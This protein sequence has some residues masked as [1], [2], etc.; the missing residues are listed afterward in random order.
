MP[1][2][3][4][5]PAAPRDLR[6]APGSVHVWRVALDGPLN[7][8]AAN[9]LSSAER[10]RAARFHFVRDR[11]RYIA[12]HGALR[13]ILARYLNADPAAL[14]FA[15]GSYGKPYLVD[16]ALSFSLSHS[17][18]MALVGVAL[19]HEVGVDVERVRA[20]ADLAAV[21]ARFFSLVE[22][23]VWRAL[24]A[25]AQTV[26][27]FACWTRKEAYMKARGEGFALPA[28]SFDVSLA[29][30][31]PARLL[32]VQ[33]DAAEAA[34]WSLVALDAG[35]GYEAALAFAG[36]MPVIACHDGA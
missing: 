20:V 19:E 15:A 7:A 23:S 33:G 35:A 29:P 21:A 18:E 22:L 36:P 8:A 5:W 11:E 34:R 14:V 16:Q 12:A 2:D 13:A 31:E 1:P 3:A 25:P 24:P 17:G 4:G 27:F 10:E 32:A 30:G 28:S 9:S 6:L 26:A